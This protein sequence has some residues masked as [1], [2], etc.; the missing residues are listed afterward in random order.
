MKNEP[1]N[2]SEQQLTREEKDFCHLYVYGGISYAGQHAKCY[3]EIFYVE[4]EQAAI[5]GRQLLS[6]SHIQAHIKDLLAISQAEMETLAVKLQ[7]A[8]TLKSVMEETA[9]SNYEDKFGVSLSP[10][11]LRAVS[12]NAAKALME[13][14]PIKHSL[15]S[16]IKIEGE[17]G[18]IFNVIVP[19]HPPKDEHET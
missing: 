13:I 5:A 19:Q 6:Q 18:V 12:V 1:L 15:D 11:P 10:A 3:K 7:V 4:E 2:T 9:T 17:G 8:E 14:Y 16:R